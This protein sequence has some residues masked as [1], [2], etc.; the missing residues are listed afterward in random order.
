MK[1]RN[2]IRI[3]LLVIL[4]VLIFTAC[5]IT[6]S[7]TGASIAS[8][9]K[10]FSVY[11]F[12]NRAKLVNPNLSQQ[13]TQGQDGLEN[14]LIKQTSLNQIK[15]NGDLEFSGQITE[16]DVKPMNIVQG[17]LAAQNRLTISVKVKFTNNKD[18]EQDWEKTFTQYE[19]FDSNRSLTDVEDALASAIIKKLVDDIF[20]ASVANW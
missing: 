15:E 20:N 14:K 17:D 1:L 10:T 11:Y 19:D 6:Y 18:H 8:N 3:F 4:V 5:K 13:F 7:F 9:V 16:Y 12:P 2:T